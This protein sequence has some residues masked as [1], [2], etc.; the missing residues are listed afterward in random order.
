MI[1]YMTFVSIV[2]FGTAS[3]LAAMG[4]R[5]GDAVNSSTNVTVIAK[6]QAFPVFA[7]I[8]LEPCNQEDCSDVTN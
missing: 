1:R 7:P 6:N 3:A 5:P 4:P 8:I 2:V